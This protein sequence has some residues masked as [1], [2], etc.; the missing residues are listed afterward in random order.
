MPAPPHVTDS[1]PLTRRVGDGGVKAAEVDEA[2]G[3]EEEVGDD[4][5]DG[6]QLRWEDGTFTLVSWW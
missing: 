3:T 5:S 6:V 1:R 2:V 4:G